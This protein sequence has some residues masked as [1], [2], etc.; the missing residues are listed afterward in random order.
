MRTIKVAFVILVVLVFAFTAAAILAAKK[1]DKRCVIKY[2]TK[3]KKTV[4]KIPPC[5]DKTPE[6]VPGGGPFKTKAEA[7][8]AKEKLC[9]SKQ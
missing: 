2:T 7:Q 6:T 9:P 1:A 8:K 3:D 4:C 5:K